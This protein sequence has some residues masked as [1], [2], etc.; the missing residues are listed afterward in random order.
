MTK[1]RLGG[2]ETTGVLRQARTYATGVA[3]LVVIAVLGLPAVPAAAQATAAAPIDPTTAIGKAP[4]LPSGATRKR[5]LPPSTSLRLTVILNPS[6][7][8]GLAALARDVST[9]GSPQYHHY[10]APGQFARAY[11]PAAKTIGAVRNQ[12]TRLGLHLGPTSAN[13]LSIPVTTTAGVAAAAF[14]VTL[15]DVG[16]PDG[17]PAYANTDAP[18]ITTALAPDIAGVLGLDSLSPEVSQLVVPPAPAHRPA[19]PATPPATRPSPTQPSAAPKAVVPGQTPPA[20]A[21]TGP[22]PCAAATAGASAYG[23]Y[24]SDQLAQA[25]D[26]GGL[27]GQGTMGAGVTV[28]LVELANFNPSDIATFQTCFG[29]S[30]QV[31]TVNVDGGNPATGG[32]DSVE[33]ELDIEDVIGLAPQAVV[34]PYIAEN[35]FS[36]LYDLYNKIVS[37]DNAKVVSASWAQCESLQPSGFAA[38]ENTLFEQAAVQGQSIFAAAGDNGST[39]CL[40][41]QDLAVLDPASNPLVTG[42]G[43]TTLETASAPPT[44]VTWNN[45]YNSG[46]GGISAN[47]QMAAGQQG[48]GV[49][50]AYSTGPV[51]GAPLGALCREVPDVSAS[52]DQYHGY[53]IYYTGTGLYSSGWQ[54]VGGTSAAAPLWAAFAALSDQSCSCALGDLNPALYDI[55][56]RESGGFN[57]ITVGNNDVYRINGG[58]YPS[59]LDY[60]QATGLGTPDGS[61]LST[62]LAAVATDAGEA[63][64]FTADI[65]PATIG[66]G[67]AFGYTFAA[68]GKPAAAFAVAS[69]TLPSGLTLNAAT[70]LLSGTPTAIGSYHF[71]LTATNGAGPPA[72]S[73]PLAIA[74]VDLVAPA[75]TSPNTA[76]F[77]AGQQGSF[78]VTAT[79]TPTPAIREIGPMPVGISL[80]NNGNGTAILSGASTRG[81]SVAFKVTASNGTTVSQNFTLVIASPPT[82]TADTPAAASLGL[83]YGY[84]FATSGSPPPTFTVGSGALPPGLQLTGDGGLWGTPT[85]DGQYSFTLVA[86]NGV[87]PPM[88]TPAL[89]VAVTTPVPGTFF[90]VAGKGISYGSGVAG[91]GGPAELALMGGPSAMAIDGAGNLYVADILDNRVRKI[92]PAGIVTDFAGSPTG[93]AGNSGDG[94]LATSALLKGPMGVAVD[95]V[96]NVYIADTGNQRIRKVSPDG[97]ITNFA[98]NQNGEYGN[99]GDGG[100]ATAAQFAGPMGMAFDSAGDLFVADFA[101]YRVREITTAGIVSNFAGSPNGVGGNSGDGGQAVQAL[102]ETPRDVAVDVAGN[103]IISDSGNNRIR[104]VSRSGVITNVAGSPSAAAGNTGDGGPAT[105]AELSYPVGIATD[106]AGSLYIADAGNNRIRMV[107]PAGTVTD[108]AGSATGAV[109]FNDT[110]SGDGGPATSA[111]IQDPWNVAVGGNGDVYLSD[112]NNRVDGVY[113]TSPPPQF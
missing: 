89:S 35:S 111:G 2:R 15:V 14:G 42:V 67:I 31:N 25:Y 112:S 64:L 109:G 90:S 79:G 59:T 96:G 69:G 70:G 100:P 73:P 50:N 76:T 20:V 12:L 44:E 108:F 51:C 52:A 62:Q 82:F 74:V 10:L 17:Q 110:S 86:N 65:P 98:G 1:P 39:A 57:D 68:L 105:S 99:V 91:D 75:L 80:V 38:E 47:W 84:A 85:A 9:P 4:T 7:P 95:S 60:D 6:H 22:Q 43:G 21:S 103:V 28:A 106:P 72:S 40:G 5:P 30:A 113:E 24:T 61:T 13:G 93:V 26:F 56:A 46:G 33:V 88:T 107:D 104:E 77:L 48:P 37:D 23:A 102:L 58:A 94:G 63:P 53:A 34:E 87:G 11:A 45:G 3:T 41:S 8:D 36:E 101:N 27:Y 32:I 55:A 78:T 18:R 92:T 66:S 83:P 16:L 19:T 97:V 49:D 29:T 71:T 81:T 54:A